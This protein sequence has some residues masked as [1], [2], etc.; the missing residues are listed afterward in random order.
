LRTQNNPA[1]DCAGCLIGKAQKLKTAP[2]TT[3][4]YDLISK[5][6]ANAK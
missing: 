2:Q 5:K 3:K 1:A 6:G 4:G